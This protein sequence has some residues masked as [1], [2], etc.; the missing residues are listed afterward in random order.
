[1]F[2]V[3]VGNTEGLVQIL[4]ICMFTD[5]LTE[6]V[7]R[8]WPPTARDTGTSS[9]GTGADGGDTVTSWNSVNV[10]AWEVYMTSG[11]R[12]DKLVV[13]S[14]ISSSH[15]SVRFISDIAIDR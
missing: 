3:C 2:I 11:P 14:V 1:M 9:P 4:F 15:F 8:K 5:R 7:K 12:P 10:S 13:R 6:I